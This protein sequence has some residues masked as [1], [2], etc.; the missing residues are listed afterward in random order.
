MFRDDDVL[1]SP[2]RYLE[3][4]HTLRPASEYHEDYGTVLWW[5]LPIEEPPHV[6]TPND[7]DWQ[8]AMKGGWSPSEWYTH[9]TPIPDDRMLTSSDGALVS[10]KSAGELRLAD[11]KAALQAAL[12]N[13]QR[14]KTHSLNHHESLRGIAAMAPSE[15]ARMQQWA[16]D[17]LSGYTE[18]LESTLLQAVD[19]KN[20]ALE[21]LARATK[22]RDGLAAALAVGVSQLEKLSAFIGWLPSSPQKMRDEHEALLAS[23]K[24][25][26][27]ILAA[28]DRQ[29]A[30]R[31]LREAI[32]YIWPYASRAEGLTELADAYERGERELPSA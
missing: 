28:H 11:A 23:L 3:T 20:A 10:D 5:H 29:V 22:E 31:V 1:K 18:P 26:T 16:K 21:D 7:T 12:E 2:S 14:W 13:V 17:A 6:G 8:E 32:Q 19:E 27:A 9:W 30:A 15:G 4:L 24:T 25:P